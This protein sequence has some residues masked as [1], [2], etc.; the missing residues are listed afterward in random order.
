M[1]MSE[2]SFGSSSIQEPSAVPK[3]KISCD[4]IPGP[5]QQSC[6][7]ALYQL[8]L[9]DYITLRR[10]YCS[11]LNVRFGKLWPDSILSMMATWRKQPVFSSHF[12][13]YY[14]NWASA[15]AHHK[16][17]QLST[18]NSHSQSPC[19]VFLIIS[20]HWLW[21]DAGCKKQKIYKV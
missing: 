11:T 3:G 21:I 16:F 12:A 18:R 1:Q 15:T 17:R 4:S 20:P 8:Q 13:L 5:K 7:C 6:C 10:V 2:P 9:P 19:P 14:F